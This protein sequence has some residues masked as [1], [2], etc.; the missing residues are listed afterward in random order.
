MV[1]GTFSSGLPGSPFLI[2]RGDFKLFAKDPNT[3]D[4]SNLVYEFDTVGKNDE[5]IH[6]HGQKNVGPS[7]A[8]SPLRTWQATSMLYVTLT[9]LDGS[10]VGKGILRID[11]SD[12]L[13]ELETLTPSSSGLL[14]RLQSGFNFVYYFAR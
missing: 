6:F 4:Q 11:A 7:I 5:I 3:L 10:L 14:S 1:T 8:F 13:H 9:R 12:I 2:L